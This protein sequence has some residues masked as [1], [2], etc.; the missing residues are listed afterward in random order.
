VINLENAPHAMR[1]QKAWP[2]SPPMMNWAVNSASALRALRNESVAAMTPSSLARPLL[3]RFEYLRSCP[4]RG[5]RHAIR[6]TG[7][8]DLTHAPEMVKTLDPWRSHILRAQ[9]GLD[10]GPDERWK[11]LRKNL[12]SPRAR[13]PDPKYRAEKLRR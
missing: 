4:G 3:M 10:G 7:R 9:F 12:E 1:L 5:P 2:A 6:T 13:S 11:R 8:E